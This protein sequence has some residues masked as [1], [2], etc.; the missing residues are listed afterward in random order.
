MT[1]EG[2]GAGPGSLYRNRRPPFPYPSRCPMASL[3]G[4]RAVS[5]C[6][7]LPRTPMLSYDFPPSPF[8]H[9]VRRSPLSLPHY[10]MVSPV[11]EA[12]HPAS[13]PLC[14]MNEAALATFEFYFPWFESARPLE[15]IPVQDPSWTAGPQ[16]WGGRP[17]PR[18]EGAQRPNLGGREGGWG[19]RGTLAC[20][21]ARSRGR[22]AGVLGKA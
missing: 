6:L 16:A 2:T 14:T 5:E 13:H 7:A 3:P 8:P 9:C 22:R 11:S 12:L 20:A 4:P 19:K 10:Y 17:R 15:I 1:P 21:N 18:G